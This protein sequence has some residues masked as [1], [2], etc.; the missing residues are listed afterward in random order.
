[1]NIIEN[2]DGI[3]DIVTDGGT[4]PTINSLGGSGGG[5]GGLRGFNNKLRAFR[6]DALLQSALGT[7]LVDGFYRVSPFLSR[8]LQQHGI[9]LS[10]ARS[11]TGLLAALL[12]TTGWWFL[13]LVAVP[14]ILF[15]ARKR[16][17]KAAAV[18]AVLLLLLFV[19]VMAHAGQL[20]VPTQD[21]VA[22]AQVIVTGKIESTQT[23]FDRN[24]RI[25]T[26]VVLK[27]QDVVKGNVNR[28]S[29]LTFTVIGG[30]YGSLAMTVPGLPNFT[31]D[32]QVL[33]YL[34]D[35]PGYGLMPFG[36][37]RSKV[38]IFL[39]ETSGEE[40]LDMSRDDPEVNPPAE[41]KA[42]PATEGEEAEAG[43]EPLIEESSERMPVADY[44]DFLRGLVRNQRIR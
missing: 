20:P 7:A 36:G 5:T 37:L 44:L 29:N 19:P 2:P 22:K 17:L 15:T 24:N 4:I 25:F 21:L 30:I 18:T 12:E 14:G 1:M 31:R 10:M 40:V 11:V 8:Q 32:E 42:L 33:L 13:A 38:N 16:F 9:L 34:V 23:R 28:G 39:D 27:V 3:G 26:D 43:G 6:D 41:T 35:Y